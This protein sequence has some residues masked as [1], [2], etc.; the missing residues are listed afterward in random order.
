MK[1]SV[2]EKRRP[3]AHR[4][5]SDMSEEQIAPVI[6]Y[7]VVPPGCITNIYFCTGIVESF[8]FLDVLL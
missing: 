2:S 8:V 4:K 3:V 6:L 7:Q 5:P 1:S